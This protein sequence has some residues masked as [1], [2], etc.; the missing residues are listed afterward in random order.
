MTVFVGCQSSVRTFVVAIYYCVWTDLNFFVVPPSCVFI[1]FHTLLFENEIQMAV[2]R[3]K[4]NFII[5]S[6]CQ[7]HFLCCHCILYN[8]VCISTI[9]Y[10]E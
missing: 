7:C 9:W 2:E 1:T 5:A 4:A 10:I 8:I 3:K 6:F